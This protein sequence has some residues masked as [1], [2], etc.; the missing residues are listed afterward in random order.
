MNTLKMCLNWKVISSVAALGVGLFVFAPNLAAAALPFLVLAICP[1]SMILMM[2]AM[3]NMDSGS[4]SGAACAMGHQP[5]RN[6]KEQLAQLKVQ[7]QELT[8][9]IA[10]LAEVETKPEA[11]TRTT[12]ATLTS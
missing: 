9:Q 3:S 8:S 6:R 1:L 5:S 10:A 4:Q 7:Q 11:H 12:A 2:G